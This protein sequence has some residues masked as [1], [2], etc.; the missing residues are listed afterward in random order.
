M[1]A[2]LGLSAL[3]LRLLLGLHHIL[4]LWGGQG[5]LPFSSLAPGG[6]KTLFSVPLILGKKG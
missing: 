1:E 5:L 4:R 6:T 3:S 2:V